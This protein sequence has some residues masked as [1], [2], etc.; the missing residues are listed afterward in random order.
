MV[1][2]IMIQAS[3]T[4]LTLKGSFYNMK[5]YLKLPV[6]NSEISLHKLPKSNLYAMKDSIKYRCITIRLLVYYKR[7]N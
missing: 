6:W 3:V 4:L 1:G 7:W 5:T 2:I